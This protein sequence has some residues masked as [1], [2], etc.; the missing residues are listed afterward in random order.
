MV[1]AK[2]LCS[3]TGSTIPL[4]NET[5]HACCFEAMLLLLKYMSEE[6]MNFLYEETSVKQ[7]ALD[8]ALTFDF[9]RETVIPL[10]ENPFTTYSLIEGGF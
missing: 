7:L 2:L 10:S 1:L 5:E 8:G 4:I 6:N 3:D 9:I